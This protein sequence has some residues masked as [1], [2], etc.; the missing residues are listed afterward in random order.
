MID[1]IAGL[2]LTGW[3]D[4]SGKFDRARPSP[5]IQINGRRAAY[6]FVSADASGTGRPVGLSETDVE[7]FMRAKAAIYSAASLMLKEAGLG[8]GD[9]STFY[10]AG[11]FGRFL[12]FENAVAV[13]LLPDIAPDKFRY[14]GNASLSGTRLCLLSKESRDTQEALA[15]RMTYIDLSNFFG[16]MD[17]YTAAL[18]LPHT[19]IRHF[20]SVKKRLHASRP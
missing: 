5:F 18:F 4:S 19:E 11:G 17:Q 20:P 1:L 9:L 14:V 8:F 2:F 15:G 3:L 13:G 10:V 12:N 16:Y 7:N 6:T